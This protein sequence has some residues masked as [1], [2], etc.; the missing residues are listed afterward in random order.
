MM[1]AL[2]SSRIGSL[3]CW[4]HIQTTRGKKYIVK[5]K[6][7][8]L[9]LNEYIVPEYLILEYLNI[10]LKKKRKIKVLNILL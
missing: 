10:L 2:K 5:E 1:S 9:Y 4:S 8:I 3:K 6:I 7:Y